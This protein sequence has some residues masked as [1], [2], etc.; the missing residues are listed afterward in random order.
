[1]I[2]LVVTIPHGYLGV[3]WS[4]LLAWVVFWAISM[5]FDMLGTVF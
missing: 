1:M 4:F 3:D 2:L 5:C